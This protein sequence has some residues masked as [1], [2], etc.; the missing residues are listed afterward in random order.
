MSKIEVIENSLKCQRFGMRSLL[1]LIGVGAAIE[2][3]RCYRRV[4]REALDWNPASRQ[5]R[6]GRLLAGLGLLITFATLGIVVLIYNGN[7]DC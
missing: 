1:P 5:L 4:R 6:I 7:L 3:L 2:A